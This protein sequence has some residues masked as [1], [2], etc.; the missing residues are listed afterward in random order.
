M[1]FMKLLQSTTSSVLFVVL[2]KSIIISVFCSWIG[3]LAITQFYHFPL[4]VSPFFLLVTILAVI[5]GHLSAIVL[6][7]RKTREGE[8]LDSSN[9]GF[10]SFT[11]V[12]KSCLKQ[13]TLF[14]S[15]DL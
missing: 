2:V 14:P 5:V 8:E 3:L 7:E 15:F 13:K 10:P 1:K 12:L 4:L 11:L 6:S 9:K